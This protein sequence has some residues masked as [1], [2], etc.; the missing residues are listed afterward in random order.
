MNQQLFNKTLA[1][2]DSARETQLKLLKFSLPDDT[3]IALDTMEQD[4]DSGNYHLLKN[5]LSIN[6]QETGFDLPVTNTVLV[7]LG[8]NALNEETLSHAAAQFNKAD[9][10]RRQSRIDAIKQGGKAVFDKLDIMTRMRQSHGHS[11]Y[12]SN[13]RLTTPYDLSDHRFYSGTFKVGSTEYEAVIYGQRTDATDPKNV[14]VK[15]DEV[16]I[17]V[18]KKDTKSRSVILIDAH[19]KLPL[20]TNDVNKVAELFKQQ[21]IIKKAISNDLER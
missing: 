11:N 3:M 4:P 18:A 20:D 8:G 10:D 12:T 17:S 9:F 14:V 15:P 5:R 6:H 19:A 13:G 16:Q 1:D 21:P 7:S 2:Y